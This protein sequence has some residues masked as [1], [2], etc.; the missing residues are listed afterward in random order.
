[1]INRYSKVLLAL[2]VFTSTQAS[3]ADALYSI[4]NGVHH[5]ENLGEGSQAGLRDMVNSQHD[6]EN[7]MKSVN[8]GIVGHSGWGT[9][10][11]HDY[12]SYGDS[13]IKWNNVMGLA[14]SGGGSGDLGGAISSIANQFPI[15]QSQF[16]KGINNPAQQQYYALQSQTVLA[17]RAASQLDYDKIQNQIAYQRMLQDQIENAKDLKSA[18]DLNNRIQ[19]EANLINLEILREQ[20]LAN[21]QHAMSEQ[22][23]MNT[24]FLHAKFLTKSN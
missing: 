15:N 9:Y 3:F 22:A 19:L 13:A 24:A 7:L 2:L 11:T 12:Q 18:V 14:K 21:Q 10:Q 23:N 16:N 6:I 1:M 20:S 5:L 4:L 8:N 17:S